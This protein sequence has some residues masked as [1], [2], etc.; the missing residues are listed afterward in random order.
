MIRSGSHVCSPNWA[1]LPIAANLSIKPIKVIIVSLI[2]GVRLKIVEK[3][4][5]PK[6]INIAKNLIEK[7]ISPT[8]LTTSALIALLLAWI[9]VNQKLISRYDEIPMPSHDHTV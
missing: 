5:F 1:L 7:N 2:K 3:L 9:R 6:L 4:R 8:R